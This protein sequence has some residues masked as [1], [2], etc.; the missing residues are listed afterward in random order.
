[1]SA[2]FWANIGLCGVIFFLVV[3]AVFKIDAST[4]GVLGVLQP[5][6]AISASAVELQDV[7]TLS[8]AVVTPPREGHM[9]EASFT[10]ENEGG[11]DI[12]NIS[13]LCTLFD[14]A[15]NEQGRDKW[16]VFDMVK[17][18]ATRSFT[19]YDKMFISGSAVRSECRIADLQLVGSRK[20]GAHVGL[21][22]HQGGTEVPNAS[23]SETASQH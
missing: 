3:V 22:G 8:H 20:R 21:V 1:M 5:D 13:I 23:A 9:V 4:R 7:V 10:V 2:K 14:V 12:K 11:R 17:A 19:F 15:G 16:L 18:E 6:V